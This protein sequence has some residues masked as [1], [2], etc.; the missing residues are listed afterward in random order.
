M[1]RL[2]TSLRSVWTR[3]V[4]AK[5]WALKAW[6]CESIMG[7]VQIQIFSRP[8]NPTT[9]WF[10]FLGP[11]LGLRSFH[12]LS[13]ETSLHLSSASIS[14]GQFCDGLRTISHTRLHVILQRTYVL[15]VLDF[16][17]IWYW[18]VRSRYTTSVQGQ[19]HVVNAQRWPKI[20][21]RGRRIQQRVRILTSSCGN[22]SS[23]FE[24]RITTTTFKNLLNADDFNLGPEIELGLEIWLASLTFN[25]LFVKL[26]RTGSIDVVRECR[27]YFGVELP[28]CIIKKKQDKFLSRY[29]CVENLFC[30]YCSKLWS[31]VLLCSELIFFFYNLVKLFCLFCFYHYMVNKDYH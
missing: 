16:A 9:C 5:N 6:L 4:L 25:Q 18:S 1:P 10:R 29:N 28:S 21:N 3:Q 15:R 20:S 12:V 23:N 31:F 17:E 7:Q 26:F 30:R 11:A 27:S 19:G 8:V 13:S 24:P 14:L 22:C 2:W